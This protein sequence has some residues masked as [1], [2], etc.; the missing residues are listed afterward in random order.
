LT[1]LPANS[2]ARDVLWVHAQSQ[3]A[4][5]RADFERFSEKCEA[6]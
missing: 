5:R 4:R 3:I 2:A 1:L 6:R